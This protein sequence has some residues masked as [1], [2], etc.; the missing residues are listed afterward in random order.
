MKEKRLSIPEHFTQQMTS[1][2]QAELIKYYFYKL[3]VYKNRQPKDFQALENCLAYMT[4]KMLLD[5]VKELRAFSY[6][7]D[8]KWG[9]LEWNQRELTS[10]TGQVP[11]IFWLWLTAHPNGYIREIAWGNLAD[12][13]SNHMLVFLL[14]AVNDNVAELRKFAVQQLLK[15]ESFATE[16]MI[17]SL[18]FIQ[19]LGGLGHSENRPIQKYMIQLLVENP[20]ILLKAQKSVDVFIYRYA[21]EL[22]YLPESMIKSESIKN[23][24]EK[25]DKITL[26]RTFRE[27]VGT[28]DDKERKVKELLSHPQTII[29]KLASIWCYNHLDKEEAMIPLLLDSAISIRYLARDYIRKYFPEFD[30]RLYYHEHLAT[31]E[32]NA[33]QGLAMLLD[34]RDKEEMLKRSNDPRKKVRVAVLSWISCLPMEDRLDYAIAGLGDIAKDVRKKSEEQLGEVYVYFYPQLK[35]ELLERFRRNQEPKLQRSILTVLTNGSRKE[36]LFDLFELYPFSAE[37]TIQEDIERRIY[38]WKREWNRKFFVAFTDEEEMKL[39]EAEKKVNF[40]VF[41]SSEK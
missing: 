32:V 29:R 15:L 38:T 18:P 1:E 20:E 16:E 36:Y 6:Q 2:S 19:R 7:K 34:M 8:S 24:F 26:A 41:S 21:F 27:F 30:I 14:L 23:G 39:R 3:K 10:F 35:I 13:P 9:W 25:V 5:T 11:P 12:R 28:A 17:F 22:S 31:H 37:E 33:V 40:F 4:P